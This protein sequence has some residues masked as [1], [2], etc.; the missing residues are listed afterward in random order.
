MF[1]SAREAP[2]ATAFVSRRFN[3]RC[4]VC[5]KRALGRTPGDER[6]DERVGRRNE[7]H[8][9]TSPAWIGGLRQ[10]RFQFAHANSVDRCGQ[11]LANGLNFVIGAVQK[12]LKA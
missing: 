11:R 10:E 9:R 7:R 2:Q 6:A 12:Y 5:R 3:T 4:F 8:E 1:A